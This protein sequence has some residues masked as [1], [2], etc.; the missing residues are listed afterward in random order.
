MMIDLLEGY[1]KAFSGPLMAEKKFDMERLHPAITRILKHYGIE[2]DRDNPVNQDDSLADT[3]FEAA[4]DLLVEAGVYC[5]STQG[6]IQFSRDEL[7]EAVHH[8]PGR[9]WFEEGHERRLFKPR[10][11]D[12]PSAS[13]CHVGSGVATSSEEIAFRTVEGYARIHEADSIAAPC[14]SHLR[15]IP[16]SSGSPVEILCPYDYHHAPAPGDH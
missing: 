12:N 15:K 6:V 2:Y 10:R 9:C 14:I 3:V 4:K 16:A 1:R 11:P 8:T 7:E 13:W 5:L